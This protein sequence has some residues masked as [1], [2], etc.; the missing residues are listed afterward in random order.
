MD[1][2]SINEAQKKTLFFS[3]KNQFNSGFDMTQ[4]ELNTLWELEGHFWQKNKGRYL[5]GWMASTIIR[6][7]SLKKLGKIETL[8][9]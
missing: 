9:F 5:F 1:I 7:K 3:L 6:K 4:P 8:S 2:Y